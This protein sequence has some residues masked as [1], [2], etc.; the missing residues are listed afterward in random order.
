MNDPADQQLVH[1]SVQGDQEAFGRLVKKYSNAVYSVA[2]GLLNDLHLAE[3]IAQEAFVKAWFK[4]DRLREPEKFCFWVMAIARRLCIDRLRKDQPALHALTDLE[5]IADPISLDDQ[6]ERAD[7]RAAIQKALH[8]LDAKHRTAVVM[9]YFGG[10]HAREIAT[11]LSVPL[12]TVESRLRRAKQK[13]KKELFTL[14][15]EYVHSNRLEDAFEKKVQARI[16]SLFHMQIPVRQLDES[17]E[18]YKTHLGFGLKEH[19]GKCAFLSL[20]TGPLL[21]LWQ[22]ADQTTANFTVDGN[23][24]PVL[25]YAT[26][27][28]HALHDHLKALGTQITH[29]QDDGFGWV[30]KFFDPN[31]NMWGVIQENG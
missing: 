2:I 19:Y 5:T 1:Q 16:H 20:S 28:V 15:Q 22:T 14:V 25:L 11:L 21:M 29:Y 6:I 18:W 12:T 3:D 24:M 8:T 7:S 26:D 17:I 27:D 4:L 9:Y 13:L 31:G 23:T 30:L 10:Y